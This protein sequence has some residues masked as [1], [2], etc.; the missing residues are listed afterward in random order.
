VLQFR[1]TAIKVKRSDK[2]AQIYLDRV[3]G[4]DGLAECQV[5]N[6]E[7]SSCTNPAKEFSDFLPFVKTVSFEAGV[8]EALLEVNLE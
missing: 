6:E 3:D 5:K 4:S 2:I 7:L 1:K 8:C